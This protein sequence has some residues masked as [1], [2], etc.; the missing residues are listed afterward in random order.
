MSRT[1]AGRRKQTQ[2]LQDLAKQKDSEPEIAEDDVETAKAAKAAKIKA[3]KAKSTKTKAKAKASSE[4][5]ESEDPATTKSGETF[6]KDVK[7]RWKF[8]KQL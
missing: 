3:T 4:S 7:N 6:L 5:E 8:Q 1:T 2:I